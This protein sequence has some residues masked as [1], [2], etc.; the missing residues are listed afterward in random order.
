MKIISEEK[1][2]LVRNYIKEFQ[3]KEGRAPSFRQIAKVC[4]FPSLQTVH[5]YVANLQSSGEI[6][7]NDFGKFVTPVNMQ[8]KSNYRSPVSW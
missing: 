3:H 1:L 6:K 8:K 7:K 4:N 2:N 5:K